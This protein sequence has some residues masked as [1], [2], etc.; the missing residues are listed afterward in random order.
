MPLRNPFKRFR[1]GHMFFWSFAAII[2]ALAA[3]VSAISYRLSVAELVKTTSF[4]QMSQLNLLDKQLGLQMREVENI[5]LAISRNS[6]LQSYLNDSED[7][8]YRR[9]ENGSAVTFDL[10]NI[11]YSTP[12]L[13]SVYLYVP[14]PY[15]SDFQGPVRFFEFDRM[16]EESWYGSIRDSDFSWIGQHGIRTNKGEESVVSFARKAYTPG[17]DY[18]AL[19]VLNM[20]AQDMVALLG[21][22][23]EQ[24][25]RALLD[26][27]GR[28][29][30]HT[31]GLAPEFYT[32]LYAE[33]SRMPGVN[34][35]DK[36]SIKYKNTLV[37]WSKL[38]G[39]DWLLMETTP[40]SKLTENSMR[41]ALILGSIGVAA[42]MLALVLTL[43]LSKQ[44][45]KPVTTLL[46]GMNSFSLGNR[47]PLPPLDYEN[48]FGALFRGF[49]ALVERN[50]EL[51][52]SL[53]KQHRLQKEAEIQALQAM[54][55]PHF[56]YNTLDQ[57]NWMAIEAEQDR[58]SQVLELM[59]RMF[60]I[61]LSNG[62]RMITVAD[63]LAHLDC[64]LQIQ[65]IR[66]GDRLDFTISAPSHLQEL[67]VP[68]L[69]LQPFVENA[70]M[71]GFY[72]RDN[73]H[74]AI[75]VQE[76]FGDLLFTIADDG[77]GLQPEA[78]AKRP[79]RR[80]GGYGI[81]NVRERLQAYFGLPYGIDIQSHPGKGTRV[82][83]RIPYIR[84]TEQWRDIRVDDGTGRR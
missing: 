65:Q 67:Y 23:D 8:D 80:T 38:F 43:W 76:S 12:V 55:N 3:V 64:Y 58:I 45:T 1:I 34:L 81:R 26:L 36:G 11:T 41:M 37:V 32:G 16:P 75:A 48:E 13:H 46:K 57:L 15:A 68:K 27:G 52:E 42:V 79:A 22:G 72:G 69:T 73:G 83:I 49:R 19:I 60:R 50:T 62:E 25:N 74:I 30:V 4:S 33:L 7:D 6:N 84:D 54:I 70:V 20:K 53:D 51:Y 24:A 56:L 78:L 77:V 2:I 63:E 10:S 59:G 39:A 35:N 9:F 66:W 31:G 21:A 14:Q 82:T 71:H 28:P 18:R 17:G 5:S 29:V 44:F 61:G 47:R 40:W